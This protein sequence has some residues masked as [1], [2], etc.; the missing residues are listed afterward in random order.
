MGGGPLQQPGHV[1]NTIMRAPAWREWFIDA[2]ARIIE[3]LALR[4]IATT[5]EYTNSEYEFFFF[6]FW[7]KENSIA[8]K[9]L[10]RWDAY[11]GEL[12]YNNG[13]FFFFTV[14]KTEYNSI[15]LYGRSH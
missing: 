2:T 6:R 11:V 3:W 10:R 9:M 7:P 8:K 14:S 5:Y 15:T 1:F 4:T 12:I 13:Y